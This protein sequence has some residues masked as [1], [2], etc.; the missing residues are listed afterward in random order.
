M[1]VE[2]QQSTPKRTLKTEINRE[3]KKTPPPPACRKEIQS[4]AYAIAEVAGYVL[5]GVMAGAF[6]PSLSLPFYALA[7]TTL[8][9][10]LVLLAAKAI[11]PY[12]VRRLSWLKQSA[13]DLIQSY[14]K[15]Q[16]ISF[17]FS[18]AISFISQNAAAA[19]A[20]I[21]GILNGII[22]ESSECRHL[23]QAMRDEQKNRIRPG[24]ETLIDS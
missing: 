9:T 23:G 12:H 16:L 14:P 6:S 8:A 1:Q 24:W 4:I 21:L 7:A 5:L 18:L 10:K 2:S 19:V 13:N 15:L 20:G 22:L 17:L 3:V 11:D